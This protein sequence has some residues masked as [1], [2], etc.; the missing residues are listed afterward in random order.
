MIGKLFRYLFAD[1]TV[2]HVLVGHVGQGA[3]DLRSDRV[4]HCLHHL[5]LLR[6]LLVLIPAVFFLPLALSDVLPHGA[7]IAHLRTDRLKN[8]R[9]GED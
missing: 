2:C 3:D 8:K 9:Q 5:L 7:K 4:G 6:P 1:V